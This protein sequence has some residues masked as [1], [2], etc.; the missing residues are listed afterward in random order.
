M[1]STDPTFGP[2]TTAAG[3]FPN[4]ARM[5]LC[6]YCGTP[7]IGGVGPCEKCGT[8]SAETGMPPNPTDG[9]TFDQFLAIAVDL[10][11]VRRSA[12]KVELGDRALNIM[13]GTL[14]HRD[15]SWWGRQLDQIC[16]IP[17]EPTRRKDRRYLFRDFD[18]AV[19]HSGT[20]E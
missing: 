17:I 4:A 3:G 7:K 11:G 1:P 2:P 19:I 20:L 13:M 8:W 14:T 15:P 9:R 18:G 10:G 6:W 12:A 5:W 16:G